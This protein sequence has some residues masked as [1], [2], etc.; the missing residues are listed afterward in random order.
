MTSG[1]HRLTEHTVRAADRVARAA[2]SR[3]PTI[4]EF[5]VPAAVTAVLALGRALRLQP[6][7]DELATQAFASV[8]FDELWAAVSHVDLVVA[9]FYAIAHVVYSVMPTDLGLRLPSM[10]AAIG[11]VVAT[12]LL[13]HR[14]WGTRAGF[15]AGMAV[16][17]NP[18]AVEMATTARPSALA[19]L[20]VVLAALAVDR[21]SAA[22]RSHVAAWWAG[23][24]ASVAAAGLMHLFSLLAIA[25]IVILAAAHGRRTVAAFTAATCGAALLTLPFALAARTQQN[26]I[27]WIAEPT[28]AEAL[29]I[30]ANLVTS[31]ARLGVDAVDVAAIVIVAALVVAASVIIGHAIAQSAGRATEVIELARYGYALAATLLPWGVLLVASMTVEPVLRTAYIAPSIVGLSLLVAGSLHAVLTRARPGSI[32]LQRVTQLV[33]AAAVASYVVLAGATT[34]ADSRVWR[35]DDFVGLATA[36]RSSVAPG[37]VV[38]VVQ[39]YHETGLAAGLARF[40]DDRDLAADVSARL[41]GGRQPLV[42]ARRVVSTAPL[43]TAELGRRP[44]GEAVWLVSTKIPLEASERDELTRLDLECAATATRNDVERF[45]GLRFGAT[46]CAG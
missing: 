13:A 19:T 29:G 31:P 22:P 30:L 39:R 40:T 15:V 4:A 18:L 27:G 44:E 41:P 46:G 38:V 7:R 10:L 25:P 1:T 45:G 6:S 32:R 23:Y 8:R 28:P 9:P 21:A 43:R 35:H 11:V 16:A 14:W 24:A 36:V 33:A 42:E 37:D 3:A 34:A 2:L 5:A 26:Q 17:V 20:F 12:T